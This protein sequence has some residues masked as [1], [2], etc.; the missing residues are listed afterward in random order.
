MLTEDKFNSNSTRTPPCTTLPYPASFPLATP[1]CLSLPA[2]LYT[3]SHSQTTPPCPPLP[4]TVT[5]CRT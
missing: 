1:P 2:S 3:A 4:H 5:K